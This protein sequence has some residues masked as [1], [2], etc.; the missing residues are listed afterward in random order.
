M[1]GNVERKNAWRILEA[2]DQVI[3]YDDLDQEKEILNM[4]DRWLSINITDESKYAEC[5]LDA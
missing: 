2:L 5:H 3:D 1:R 4:E